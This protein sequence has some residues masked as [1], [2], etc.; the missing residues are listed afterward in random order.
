MAASTRPGEKASSFAVACSLLSRYVR[1]NGA[2]A[3]ELS[4]GF[5][6][7]EQAAWDCR[8]LEL[9]AVLVG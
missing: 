2:A 4:L 3:A 7:G 8:R 6:K 5:N 1:Q 9:V